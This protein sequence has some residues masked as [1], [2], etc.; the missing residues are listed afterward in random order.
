MLAPLVTLYPE[1]ED[2]ECSCN[3]QEDPCE[4]VTA[5]VI[6]LKQARAAGQAMPSPT[7]P[8]G[9]L[10]Y[11]FSEGRDRELAFERQIVSGDEVHPLTQSLSAIAAGKGTGPSFDATP[12]DFAVD[13]TLGTARPGSLSR[14]GMAKLLV[15]LAGS[16]RVVLGERPVC[17]EAEP[18]VPLGRV[19]DA[20]GG[21]RLY[22]EHKNAVARRT[23]ARL[24]M[25][26]TPYRIYETEFDR[27]PP[28]E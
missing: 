5:A 23:Y 19:V 13:R 24:G 22:V 18:V 4:H 20:P 12:H 25:T 28:R 16:D 6:A 15:A 27:S 7:R 14:D 3:A 26:E 2:W 8:T 17:V 11:R 21:V 10:R 1:D 9:R